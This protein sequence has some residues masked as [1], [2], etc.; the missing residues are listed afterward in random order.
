[1]ETRIV[2]QMEFG[3]SAE[4]DEMSDMQTETEAVV[5]K[6]QELIARLKAST[7]VINLTTEK[8][9]TIG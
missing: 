5:D 6:R 8:H 2:E 1:M 3:T 4:V 9:E 7:Q